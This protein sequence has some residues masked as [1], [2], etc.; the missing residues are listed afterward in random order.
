MHAPKLTLL[1]APLFL[2]FALIG[3]CVFASPGTDPIEALARRLNSDPLWP[4]GEAPTISLLSNA[5]PKEVVASAVKMWGFDRGHIKTYQILEVRNIQLAAMP[6]CSAAL[7][8]S[9]L[10]TKILLFR[11]ERHDKMSFWWARFYDAPEAEPDDAGDSTKVEPQVVRQIR[12]KLPAG[13]NCA[14]YQSDQVTA[15]P[16]GLGK[17][18]F[19]V[20]TSNTNVSFSF[21]K[22]PNAPRPA[23]Q[24]PIIPLYFYRHNDK[25]EVMKIIEKEAMYS[26]SIPVYFG[27]TDEFVVVT[28]PAFVNGGVFTHEARLALRP[29][30]KVLR[31]LIPKKERT[32]VDEMAADS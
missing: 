4:N 7:V 19:E 10:G 26:W 12:A 23:M 16:H 30:W 27:E 31:D 8:R 15:V 6:G 9:D 29:M 25:L 28:S 14:M 11:Y 22:F 21:V 18:V 13:W 20:V 5:A 17:P 32:L 3:G 2:G 1:S 24:S